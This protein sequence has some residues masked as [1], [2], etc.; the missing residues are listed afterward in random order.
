MGEVVEM[1]MGIYW[2]IDVSSEEKDLGDNR[3]DHWGS[4][5][6]GGSTVMTLSV[7]HYVC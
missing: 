4:V 3:Q 7:T 5:P 1:R 6:D 2:D